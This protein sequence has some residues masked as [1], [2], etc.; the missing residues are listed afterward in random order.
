MAIKAERA[1]AE[2]IKIP[3]LLN[4]KLLM[5]SIKKIFATTSQRPESRANFCQSLVVGDGFLGGKIMV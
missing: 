2:A 3:T 1:G 4:S 5:A